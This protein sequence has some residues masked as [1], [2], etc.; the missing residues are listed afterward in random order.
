MM[1]LISAGTILVSLISL[2]G[3]AVGPWGGIVIGNPFKGISEARSAKAYEA[4]QEEA[5]Q[6]EAAK[7]KVYGPPQVV[8]RIDKNRYITMEKY[9]NCKDGWL[10]YHN[11]ETKEVS[12]MSVTKEFL[13]YQGELIWAQKD[14]IFR[15][16]PVVLSDNSTCGGNVR[17][18]SSSFSYSTDGGKSF[19]NL[20]YSVGSSSY[21]ERYQVV[22]SNNSLYVRDMSNKRIEHHVKYSL[23]DSGE[24]YN[25]YMLQ[26]YKSVYNELLAL[27][28]PEEVINRRN[29]KDIDGTTL[30]NKYHY[31][32][33]QFYDVLATADRLYRESKTIYEDPKIPHPYL[34]DKKITCDITKLPKQPTNVE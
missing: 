26:A 1:R 30:M 31:T 18:C 33:Q 20:N 10:Y 8:Y 12:Q 7:P 19:K 5:R 27:G 13:N 29:P 15:V 11:D 24:L 23:D 17:G 6:K 9:T 25:V 34:G 14:D 32:Q 2:S 4:K 16:Y 3:C 28:V 21:S 22:I